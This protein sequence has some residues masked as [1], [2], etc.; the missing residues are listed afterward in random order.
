[1]L[2]RFWGTFGSLSRALPAAAIKAKLRAALKTAVARG[3]DTDAG[4]E[5]FLDDPDAFPMV[6]TYGGNTPCV[7]IVAA[8]AGSGDYV[9]CDA[10]TGLR[11]FGNRVIAEHG[12]DSGHTFHLFLSHA[13]WDHIQGF[14]LFVPAYIPG[15]R[16]VIHGGHATLAEVFARQQSAPFFPVDFSH[17]GADI[18]FNRLEPGRDHTIAGLTVRCQRQDH[19]GDSYGYRFTRNGHSVVYA[20]D[21]EHKFSAHDLAYP[22]LRFFRGADLLIFDAMYTL[23][24]A[25]THKEDWGH[26]SNILGVDLALEA[27]VGQLCLFHHDP[28]TSDD[29][30]ARR[31]HE[32][33][34]Y[35]ELAGE[36]RTLRVCA[37]YDGLEIAVPD[38]SAGRPAR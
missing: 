36:G 24:D 8:D 22:L 16:I 13:H 35:A 17:L 1:M 28:A 37:A 23:A 14:P 9:L 7:E 20:T 2:V 10:G 32:T 38:N 30:I 31:L 27:G 12:P 19:P 25:S 3:I 5:T 18:Q 26:S 29:A 34:R 33:I 11:D 21:S 15:N 6:G 4:I